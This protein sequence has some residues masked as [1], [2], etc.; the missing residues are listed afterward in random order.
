M[1]HPQALDE[2][3]VTPLLVYAPLTVEVSLGDGRSPA[4]AA[5]RPG[6]ARGPSRA[7]GRRPTYQLHPQ[8]LA[9][10]LQWMGTAQGVTHLLWH[11]GP[12]PAG[13]RPDRLL[14]G[15]AVLNATGL[16]LGLAEVRRQGLVFAA[17]RRP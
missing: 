5:P 9:Q 4:P 8:T 2:L 12:P 1:P 3:Q 15:R 14:F 10:A 16:P 7:A 11:P 6:P 13:P 17:V